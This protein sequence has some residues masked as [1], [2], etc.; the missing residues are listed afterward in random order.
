MQHACAFANKRLSINRA[1]SGGDFHMQKISGAGFLLLLIIIF[2]LFSG[3]NRR[4]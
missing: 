4:R 3:S 1:K 2:L